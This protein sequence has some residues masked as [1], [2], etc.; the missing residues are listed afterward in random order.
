MTQ[1]LRMW[2]AAPSPSPASLV[3]PSPPPG[4]QFVTASMALPMSSND[5]QVDT[6]SPIVSGSRFL[7]S[8]RAIPGAITSKRSSLTPQQRDAMLDSALSEDETRVAGAPAVPCRT[9]YTLILSAGSGFTA[10]MDPWERKC[11]S[12]PSVTCGMKV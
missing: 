6:S 3:A 2:A 11:S 10:R 1:L 5:P 7:R 12:K 9:H 4:C 8:V